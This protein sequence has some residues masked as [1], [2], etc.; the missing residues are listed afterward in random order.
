MPFTGVFLFRPAP[1]LGTVVCSNALCPREFLPI[2]GIVH[3]SQTMPCFRHMPSS[4]FCC[5]HTT[6][7]SHQRFALELQ[8]QT[9]LLAVHM[10]VWTVILL[11]RL[12]RTQPLQCGMFTVCATSFLLGS[13]VV[14]N[15]SPGF[16]AAE[17]F[18]HSCTPPVHC[19]FMQ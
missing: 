17:F 16:R 8:F 5:P 6:G 10:T 7:C 13:V 4:V 1:R 19:W 12:N 14:S 3:I 2:A 18:L 9:A 15:M 11:L